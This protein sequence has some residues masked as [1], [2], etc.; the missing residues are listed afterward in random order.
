MSLER[1][2]LRYPHGRALPLCHRLRNEHLPAWQDRE[3]R[4]PGHGYA[5]GHGHRPEGRGA[6]GHRGH[7]EGHGARRVCLNAYW[8]RVKR[9]ALEGRPGVGDEL[10]GY[11]GYSWSVVVELLSIAFQNGDFGPQLTGVDAQGRSMGV[12]MPSSMAWP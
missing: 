10:G 2:R 7:S 11:K 9:G 8:R 12:L 4:A 3:V 5:E 6:D 1:F